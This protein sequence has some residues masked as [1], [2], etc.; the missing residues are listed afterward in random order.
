MNNDLVKDL[1]ALGVKPGN[2]LMVHSSLKSLGADSGGASAVVDGL[3]AALG[4]TGTLLMPALSYATVNAQNP[5][6]DVRNTPVCTGELGEYFRTRPGTMRSVHPTH[7]VCGVG[8]RAEEILSHHLHDTTPVGENSPFSRLPKVGAQILF[9]G[10]GLGPNTT[11]HGVEEK[12]TPPYLF[13]DPLEYAVTLA[14]GSQTSMTV[15]QHNFKGWEQHYERLEGLMPRGMR[16]GKLLEADCYLL[17]APEMWFAA[18]TKLR[19]D[20]LFFVDHL[21]ATAIY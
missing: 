14:D 13:G 4:E 9:I 1:L 16:R 15:K 6:F 12:V 17:E 10:C 5:V 19:Q 11:M 7:S 3:L 18:L 21:S 20:P 8:R 2:T